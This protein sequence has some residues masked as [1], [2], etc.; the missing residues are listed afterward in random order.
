V[1][2]FHACEF[3]K[4]WPL[5]R[6]RA[7]AWLAQ[8]PG[9]EEAFLRE[10]RDGRICCFSTVDGFLALSLAPSPGGGNDL[11]VRLAVSFAPTKNA[12][13]E[14]LPF[15]ERV[16]RDMKAKSIRFRSARRGW[17]R[18]LTDRWSVAHVEY[19]TEVRP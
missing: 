6:H 9:G 3:E 12:V 4:V 14:H 8:T 7:L 1:K 5:V 17:E 18:H 2:N 15:V 11:F 16:A 10:C 13:E 19:Q